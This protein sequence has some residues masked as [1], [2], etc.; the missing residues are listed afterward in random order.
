[1]LGKN[2]PPGLYMVEQLTDQRIDQFHKHLF[3]NKQTKGDAACQTV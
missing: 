1:M 2:R 3:F